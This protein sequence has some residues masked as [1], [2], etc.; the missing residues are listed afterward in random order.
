M[1]PVALGGKN[2]IHMGSPQAG[3]KVAAILSV[4]ESCRRLK[5]SVR[6]YLAAI[7]SRPRRSPGPAPPRPYSRCVG[8]PAFID[9]SDGSVSVKVIL[10]QQ[11]H[12]FLFA[13]HSHTIV[14]NR[15]KALLSGNKQ[16]TRMVINLSV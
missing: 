4:V 5:I 13:D 6:D 8:R 1:R 2:W 9:S 16:T 15:C 7:P 11:L 10:R 14:R 12:S 3:P